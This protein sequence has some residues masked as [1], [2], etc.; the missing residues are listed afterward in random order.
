[1]RAA[2]DVSGPGAR[3]DAAAG[4][5]ALDSAAARADHCRLPNNRLLSSRSR[6]QPSPV[7]PFVSPRCPAPTTGFGSC[8]TPPP[9]CSAKRATRRRRCATSPRPAG[10]WRDRST[11]TSRPRKPC[12]SPSTA[13]ASGTSPRRSNPRSRGTAIRGSGWSGRAQR[14]WR[15]CFPGAIT[16]R[17]WCAFAPTTCPEVATELTALR[18]GYERTFAQA[19]QSLPLPRPTDRRALKLML[20]GALNWSQTWYRPGRDSPAVVARRFLRLLRD[21]R[22]A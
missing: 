7:P 2:P 10:C 1:M 11:T 21:A 5:A 8:W 18:D 13:K 16:R 19:I 12:W 9:A 14:I 20:L 17:S 4:P 6:W 15:R 22:D 3:Q